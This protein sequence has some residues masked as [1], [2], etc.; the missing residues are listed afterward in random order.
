MSRV[1]VGTCTWGK[2]WVE[3]LAKDK[4]LFIR[5][6]AVSPLPR[7]LP[8]FCTFLAS[9]FNSRSSAY[10]VRR[11]MCSSMQAVKCHAALMRTNG[12]ADNTCQPLRENATSLAWRM[13][14]ASHP[15]YLPTKHT[16]TYLPTMISQ[17]ADFTFI[18][19]LLIPTY[20]ISSRLH[21]QIASRNGLFSVI[22]LGSLR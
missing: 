21:R 2:T 8:P 3:T 4:I 22:L 1:S 15:M 11:N 20:T 9:S 17:L 16:S 19:A 10:R 12:P 7:L 6:Y 13:Q 5:P 18:T 14:P